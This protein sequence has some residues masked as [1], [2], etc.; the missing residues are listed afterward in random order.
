MGSVVTSS[1]VAN[2]SLDLDAVEGS[3]VRC[4]SCL[5]EDQAVWLSHGRL[6]PMLASL[7]S[8]TTKKFLEKNLLDEFY[9]AGD[10]AMHKVALS[11]AEVATHFRARVEDVGGDEDEEQAPNA[12]ETMAPTGRPP[13]TSPPPPP[14]PCNEAL[15]GKF[16]ADYRGCQAKSRSGKICQAWTSQ[17]PIKHPFSPDKYPGKGLGDH[18]YCRNPD[19]K[20]TI[21]CYITGGDGPGAKEW[22]FCDPKKELKENTGVP[23]SEKFHCAA[24]PTCKLSKPKCTKLRDRFLVILAAMFDAKTKLM[25]ELAEVEGTCKEV[26]SSYEATISAL[27]STMK[28]QQTALASATMSIQENQQQSELSSA[29]HLDLMTEYTKTM[30][31]CCANKNSFSE[32]ICALTKIRGEVYKQNQIEVVIKDCEVA[33][34]TDNECSV[35]CGGG[36]QSRTRSV[37]VATDLG[38]KCPPL[39]MERS[40][41]LQTCPTDCKV[42]DWS[43]WSSCTAECGGGVQQRVRNRIVAPDNGGLP[44]PEQS[45]SQACN[46]QACN[47]NCVLGDWADWGLCSKACSTGRELGTRTPTEEARGVGTCAAPDSPTRLRGRK[48]NDW[49]CSLMLPEGR[50][51]L[52]CKAKQDVLF[53]VDG[54][55]SLGEYGWE[56]FRNL[57]ATL[58]GAMEY[59]PPA[60]TGQGE[61]GLL[62]AEP[63]ELSVNVQVSVMVYSGPDNGPHLEACTSAG[64]PGQKLDVEAQCG[65]QWLSRLTDKVSDVEEKVRSAVWPKKTTLTSMALAEA[66]G[67]LINGR[68]D[69]NS[70]VVV[71]TDGKPMSPLKTSRMSAELKQQARLIWVPIGPGVDDTVEEMKQWA[72]EPW[73]DNVIH[74]DNFAT[75]ALPKTVNNIIST[76]CPVVK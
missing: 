52:Q 49:Q 46:V 67:E 36:K 68:Q 61:T 19:G 20:T 25:D 75:M 45:E 43:E 30:S 14:G 39:L 54:S 5:P 8:P 59:V 17:S 16:G 38:T 63:L 50:E 73:Q 35:S 32:E 3:I 76:I 18:N 62:Q 33:A 69:A 70:V 28:E 13:M 71:I 26:K 40:C 47:A 29:Q 9:A 66:R 53:L 48:C 27:E 41:S 42:D 7:K 44:C 4:T 21:W 22:D 34:W 57:T 60:P 6:S 65:I 1:T 37:I 31:E 51:F 72:S 23:T 64:L 11:Q 56:S 58:V 10:A 74:I 2:T 55:G 24:A 15:V 12:Q